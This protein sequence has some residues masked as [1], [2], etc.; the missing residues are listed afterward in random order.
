MMMMSDNEGIKLDEKELGNSCPV[1]LRRIAWGIAVR[2]TIMI[3]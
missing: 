2:R 3:T 1:T